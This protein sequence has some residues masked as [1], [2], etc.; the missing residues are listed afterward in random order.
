[1]RA[2]NATWIP[3]NNNQIPLNALLVQLNESEVYIGRCI[4]SHD[5]IYIGIINPNN[6]MSVD[7]YGEPISIANAEILVLC[8]TSVDIVNHHHRQNNNEI[9]FEHESEQ[10]VEP[11]ISFEEVIENEQEDLQHNNFITNDEQE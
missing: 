8:D 2:P 1:M 11:D 9:F 6:G 10:E 3:F 5:N 7:F 4:V